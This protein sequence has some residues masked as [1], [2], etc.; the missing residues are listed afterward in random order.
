MPLLERCSGIFIF[1]TRLRESN[2]FCFFSV[3]EKIVAKKKVLQQFP[4]TLHKK[5]SAPIDAA[6]SRVHNPLTSRMQDREMVEAA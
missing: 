3:K 5:I 6:Q 4:Q 2:F 1:S